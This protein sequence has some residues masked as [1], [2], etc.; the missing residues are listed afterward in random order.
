MKP[1]GADLKKKDQS[2]VILIVS[3]LGSSVFLT[4]L[5]LLAAFL[6]VFRFKYWKSKVLKPY[7]VMLGMNLRS[8]TYEE[9]TK[10]TNGFREELGRGAS[11]KVYKGV[12][13]YEDRKLVA[14]KR[15]NDMVNEGDL[16]FKAEVSAIGRTNH[17]NLVQLLGFCNEG[18][19]RLLVYEFMSN[20]SLASFLFG[21]SRPYW[22]Q[23]IQIALETARGL[24]Y[25]HEECSIQNHFIVISSY[26][27]SSWMTLL[28]LE[29]LTLD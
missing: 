12:L 14:V 16:E 26:R 13:E 18:Q 19:H 22:Y 23:R 3:V 29:F 20:G 24:F 2:T 27:T 9:L 11:A 17:R 15:M 6:L 1:L 7:E 5:F 28:Q 25:L 8:Y 10:A 4:L 21:V